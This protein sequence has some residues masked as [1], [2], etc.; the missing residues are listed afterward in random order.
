L[1]GGV[2]RARTGLGAPVWSDFA[3]SRSSKSFYGGSNKVDR[4]HKKRASTKDHV[5]P[6]RNVR[7]LAQLPLDVSDSGR[8][9]GGGIGNSR[10]SSNDA[11]FIGVW[12]VVVSLLR[13]R[14]FASVGKIWVAG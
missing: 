5:F 11:S 9:S 14:D 3:F 6:V 1:I 4:K 10:S 12:V 13:L 2:G 8:Q 7:K